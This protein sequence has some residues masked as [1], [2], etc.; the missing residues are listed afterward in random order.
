MRE[1][2]D[3]VKSGLES[4]WVRKEGF[5]LL[6]DVLEDEF[7]DERLWDL[8]WL[9]MISIFLPLQVF[10]GLL[11]VGLVILMFAKHA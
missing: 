5:L 11:S 1:Q 8:H 4:S 3:E 9:R 6:V 10:L 2:H 7:I